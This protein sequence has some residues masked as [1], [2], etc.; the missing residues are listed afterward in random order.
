MNIPNL[1]SI[2]RILLVPAFAAAFFR[3]GENSHLWSTGI[4]LLAGL[5]DVVDGYIARRFG[6]I[7]MLGRFLDPLADKLMVMTALVCCTI[8][9]VIP[10]WAVL[11]FAGKECAQGLCG[12]VLFKK[13]RDVPPSNILGKAGTVLFYLTIALTLVFRVGATTQLILLIISFIL[14]FT[15]FFSYISDGIRIVKEK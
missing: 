3:G 7:T 11:L 13:M 15:A 10:L 2:F 5:T 14:I 6:Q 4:F 1:L 9:G 8:G 12:L